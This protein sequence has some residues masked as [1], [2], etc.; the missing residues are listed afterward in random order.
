MDLEPVPQP[1]SLPTREDGFC[2]PP[3][4][5][6]TIVVNLGQGSTEDAQTTVCSDTASDQQQPDT[7]TIDPAPPSFNTARSTAAMYSL[8]LGYMLRIALFHTELTLTGK[9]LW[10]DTFLSKIFNHRQEMYEQYFA[11]NYIIGHLNFQEV[12]ATFVIFLVNSG[13][14]L[15]RCTCIADLV[16]AASQWPES[17]IF[18]RFLFPA[19]KFLP[20]QW[21]VR[22]GRIFVYIENRLGVFSVECIAWVPR[23]W[24]GVC[25][26]LEM[27]I[28]GCIALWI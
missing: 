18:Y 4:F 15:E 24:I 5:S 25:L 10:F 14:P 13:L 8:I 1:M 11:D 3:R 9:L 23:R 19:L 12:G 7:I 16:I 2:E 27:V 20:D 21:I 17:P 22:V 26:T 6:T 28:I